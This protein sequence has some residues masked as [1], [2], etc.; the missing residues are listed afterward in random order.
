MKNIFNALSDDSRIKI[1]ELL[2]KQ[3]LTAGDLHK[4]FDFSKPTLSHHLNILK[5]AG[6]IN[7]EK[8][9]QFI[10]YSLEMTVL[11]EILV[12]IKKI[13]GGK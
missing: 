12:F 11:D 13:K 3:D 10:Y 6:L 5:N 9:G 7:S 8:R 1:I 4:H 2:R